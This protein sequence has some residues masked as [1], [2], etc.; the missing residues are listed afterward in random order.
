MNAQF[1]VLPDLWADIAMWIGRRHMLDHCAK[2]LNMGDAKEECEK[3]IELIDLGIRNRI[4]F[5][6]DHSVAASIEAIPMPK[7]KRKRKSR[8]ERWKEYDNE[9]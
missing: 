7:T 3:F 2:K 6:Y 5:L 1:Q 9:R 4:R 8:E